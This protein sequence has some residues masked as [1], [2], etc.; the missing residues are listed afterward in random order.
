MDFYKRF[1]GDFMSKTSHLSMLKNGAY[2]M[3]LDTYYATAKP[4]PA[5][6]DSLYRICRATK[7]LEREAV[8]SV[9]NEFFPINGDGLRHNARADREIA[10]HD[11]RVAVNR[12][13]GNLGGR[14]QKTER[15]SEKKPQGF[16]EK[17]ERG[18]KT[19]PSQSQS[20]KEQKQGAF[21]PP[22]WVPLE[23]WNAYV[24]MRRAIKRPLTKWAAV[25]AVRTLETLKVQGHDPQA[26]LDQSVFNAWQG[27]FPVHGGGS[28]KV[29][30]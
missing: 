10:D 27:L 19:K 20:Q 5:D 18:S 9:A 3:L 25:L 6:W 1:V 13:V 28:K 22:E 24:E 17:T 29:A 30:L 15:V 2:S 21:A 7:P 8:D 4:L 11:E 23:A 14:P 12:L 16:Q 26:V